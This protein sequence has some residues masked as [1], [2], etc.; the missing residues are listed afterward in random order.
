MIHGRDHASLGNENFQSP[1][2]PSSGEEK[3][4]VD[5]SQ[6]TAREVLL[7][8]LPPCLVAKAKGGRALVT[9]ENLEL[10]ADSVTRLLKAFDRLAS[11][12]DAEIAFADSSGLTS[13][14]VGALSD[15]GHFE[16]LG[17]K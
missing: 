10:L 15:R 2:R 5:C 3:V 11:D 8:I 16:S 6:R 14:F 12:L 9:V 13:A 17:G 7:D 1:E 4:Y